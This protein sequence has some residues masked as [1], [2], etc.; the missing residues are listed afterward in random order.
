M[1]SAF[2]GQHEAAGVTRA[3]RAMAAAPTVRASIRVLM[4]LSL[5]RAPAAG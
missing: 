1:V 4:G 3:I 5:A 2:A